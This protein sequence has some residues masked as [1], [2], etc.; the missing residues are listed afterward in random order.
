MRSAPLVAALVVSGA[1]GNQEPPRA[2]D[3][4]A[5]PAPTASEAPSAAPG[6]SAS[7]I[8]SASAPAP[9]PAG[10]SPCEGS[11][12]DVAIAIGD[13]RCVFSDEDRAQALRVDFETKVKPPFRA[14]ASVIAGVVELRV[15]NPASTPLVIP[16]FLSQSLDTFPVTARSGA[17]KVTLRGATAVSSAAPTAQWSARTFARIVVAPK[18]VAVVRMTIDPTVVENDWS[19]CP[20]DAKCAPHAVDRGPL[21]RGAWELEVR[22]PVYAIREITAKVPW[23]VR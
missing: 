13:A 4:P 7:P 12:I 14:E 17:K 19:H 3:P 16:L 21:P 23:T 10:P 5:S 6:P 20:P 11:T 8:T 1:C 2:P 15:T 9:P 18:G 22:M